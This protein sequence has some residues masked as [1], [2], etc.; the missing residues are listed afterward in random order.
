MAQ[1]AK[2]WRKRW[3]WTRGTPR[4]PAEASQQLFEP[5]RPEAHAGVEARGAG[6]DEERAGRRPPVGA[7]GGEGV[8]TAAGE[9]HDAVLAA[10]ALPDEQSPLRQGAV[11]EVQLDR[12][13]TADAGV[14]ER[15]E[16]RAIAAAHHRG[17]VAAGEQAGDLRGCQGRHDL[18][19]QPH[20]AQAPERVVI[21]VA[22]RAQ[23]V[24][25]GSAPRG[26]SGGGYRGGGR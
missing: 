19:G 15:E 5:V 26:N 20:V 6:G 17:S 11:R 16:D 12:F 2:V 25:E 13:G 10:L 8:G 23:P 22:G 1:V 14:Q 9:G 7:I 18:A 4:G 21:R 3:A 24:P